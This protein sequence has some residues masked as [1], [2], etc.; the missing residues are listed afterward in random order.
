MPKL[1]EPTKVIYPELSYRIVGLLFHI[2]SQL[3]NRFHEKYY[4]RAVEEALKK[5]C[6]PYQREVSAP[7]QYDGRFIGKYILDFL[8]DGKIILETKA[9]PRLS[10]PDF[11]QITAYLRANNLR[12]GLLINFRGE[13][14]SVHRILH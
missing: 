11:R 9:V 14:L 8:I 1:R 13:R 4:Q 10:P 3:G 12:L 6:I 7:L 5:E 2:H